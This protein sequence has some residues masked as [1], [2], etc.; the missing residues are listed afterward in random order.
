MFDRFWP[1]VLAKNPFREPESNMAFTKDPHLGATSIAGDFDTEEYIQ[2]LYREQAMTDLYSRRNT[3]PVKYPD[4]RVSRH[5]MMTKSE[6]IE[7]R[8][9]RVKLLAMRLRVEEDAPLPW[10]FIETAFENDTV[11]VFVLSGGKPVVLEDD[12]NLFPSDTLITQL[13]LLS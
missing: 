9:F 4:L 6:S 12:A 3:Y 8:E 11:F 7:H 5:H 2:K 13:R 10:S 1:K